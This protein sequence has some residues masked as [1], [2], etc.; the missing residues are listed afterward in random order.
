M[1]PS[2]I[3]ASPARVSLCYLFHLADGLVLSLSV[4]VWC[5][6]VFALLGLAVANRILPISLCSFRIHSFPN[7]TFWDSLAC[8]ALGPH[9]P[10]VSP[11]LCGPSHRSHLLQRDLSCL[12]F[13]FCVGFVVC[14][15]LVRFCF[16]VLFLVPFASLHAL[17]LSLTGA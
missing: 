1:H 17:A 6:C 3:F 9:R 15:F 4:F 8:L 5:F 12:V 16:F 7:T 10:S 13:G 11:V 14:G 2:E